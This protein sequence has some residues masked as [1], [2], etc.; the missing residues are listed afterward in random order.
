MWAWDLDSS[1]VSAPGGTAYNI[2]AKASGPVPVSQLK[3]MLRT[4][5]AE[6]FHLKTHMEKQ[7][8]AFTV[9]LVAKGGPKLRQSSPGGEVD[10]KLVALPGVARAWIS[11]MLPCHCYPAS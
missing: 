2:S 5:L 1:S 9:L 7:D 11:A 8:R 10:R 3:L 6:R 4:L